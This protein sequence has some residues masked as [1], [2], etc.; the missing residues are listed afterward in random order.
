MVLKIRTA[1]KGQVLLDF[2]VEFA[3]VGKME[4]EM[5]LVEPPTWILFVDSSSKEICFGPRVVIVNP[6]C[7]C[8]IVL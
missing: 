8:L 6:K 3:H 4:E 1:I 5:K 2:E 7:I